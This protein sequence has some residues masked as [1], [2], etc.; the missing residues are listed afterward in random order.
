MKLGEIDKSFQ[1]LERYYDIKKTVKDS[2][3]DLP[4]DSNVALF[5][6]FANP[7]HYEDGSFN[8]VTREDATGNLT[9]QEFRIKTAIESI[10]S[11]F[12]RILLSEY[13]NDKNLQM[14]VKI[15]GDDATIIGTN[16]K[17]RQGWLGGLIIS[18]KRFAE[19]STGAI[20]EA[21]GKLFGL[22]K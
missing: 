19:I 15:I 1:E 9:E 8:A 21:G 6:K 18:S 10:R 17:S 14:T 2:M 13:P 16:S 4:A 5:G 3:I 22:R 11:N 20:K 12:I 7:E